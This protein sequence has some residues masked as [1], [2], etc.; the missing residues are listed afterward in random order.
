MNKLG[1]L[2]S[3]ILVFGL[4]ACAPGTEDPGPDPEQLEAVLAKYSSDRSEVLLA[5]GNA[6]GEE[7][8]R[9]PE[10]DRA[11][12]RH[13]LDLATHRTAT[14]M[15]EDGS[16]PAERIREAGGQMEGVR[17]FIF[18]IEGDRDDLGAIAAAT[19]L[20]PH[21]ENAVLTEPATHA[22]V[23]FAP[24]EEGGCVGVLLLAQR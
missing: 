8:G 6:R 10:L 16:S 9:S 11:A 3:L 13:A 12:M 15:G 7:L 4:A 23:A 20:A 19:W 21:D 1:I 22:A 5:I 17:E 2:L 14:H 24:L 18:R